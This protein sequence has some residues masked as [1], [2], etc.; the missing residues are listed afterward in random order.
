MQHIIETIGK[1]GVKTIPIE[2]RMN[3][4]KPGDIVEFSK[5]LRKYPVS[6]HR[7]RIDH[8]DKER[9]TVSLVDGMGSAFL[10]EGGHV[11]ISGGPFFSVPINSLEA[12]NCTAKS[13]M[14]NWGDNAPGAAQGV[15]YDIQ[16]P[17]FR[18]TVHPNGGKD[19]K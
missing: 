9:G 18:A 14:W 16:R 6:Y 19:A 13:T 2:F 7:C 3:V 12:T 15:H 5:E 11:S 4:P 1:W 8:I 17:L 10:S